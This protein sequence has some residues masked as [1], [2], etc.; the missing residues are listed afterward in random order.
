MKNLYLGIDVGSV[1]INIVAI[2]NTDEIVFKA[3][4]RTEGHPL[5]KI[6][7]G[8]QNLRETIGDDWTISGTG[9]TGSGRELASVVVGADL[10]KN[11]ITAQ[12]IAT[13]NE[14]PDVRT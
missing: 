12:A 5:E 1:S 8:L 14:K 11:E 10:V 4:E 7:T 13:I 6:T 9:T 3:Y 2:N